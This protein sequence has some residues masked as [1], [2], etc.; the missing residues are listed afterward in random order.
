MLMRYLEES[1]PHSDV[2]QQASFER[3]L[4]LPDPEL[5]HLLLGEG[6]ASDAETRQLIRR[7]RQVRPDTS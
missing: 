2:E 5:Q 4:E 3:L 1:Y 7:M 6:E